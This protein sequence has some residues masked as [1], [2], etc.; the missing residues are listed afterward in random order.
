MGEQLAKTETFMFIVRLLQHFT[1]R[2][3]DD[4]LEP[5]LKDVGGLLI[6]RPPP[7]KVCAIPR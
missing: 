7:F 6:R 3:P 5:E 2:F 1:F 4:E